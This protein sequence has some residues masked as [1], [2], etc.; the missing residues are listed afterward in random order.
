VRLRAVGA[1]PPVDLPLAAVEGVDASAAVIGT[2]PM[3]SD[4][5]QHDAALIDRE[6]LRPGNRFSGPALVIEYSTTTVVPPGV[7]AR[8]DEWFNLILEPPHQETK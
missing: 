6:R 1:A 3:V 7:G 5:G 2:Q 4:G 8:V